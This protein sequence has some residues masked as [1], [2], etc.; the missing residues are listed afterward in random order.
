[1][2]T[3]AHILID[4]SVFPSFPPIDLDINL[5]ESDN[6]KIEKKEHGFSAF[7]SLEWAIPS[8]ICAYFAKSYFDGFLN[9]MGSEHYRKVKSWVFL[10]NKKIK[11][12]TTFQMTST[13]SNKK[14]KESNSP[15]NFFS[16]Y[17]TTPRGIR[18][19]VFMPNCELD[20]D[21]VQAL[22]MLLDNFLKLYTK[23]KSR[24]A[25]KI[26]GLTDK[27]YEELY[28]IFNVEKGNWEFYT[29]DMLVKKSLNKK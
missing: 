18:M 17:L 10:L 12:E 9:E 3:N 4:Q 15:N 2:R 13:K 16:I 14:V 8:V 28:A 24:F 25:Q 1:M 5:L 11:G 26:N 21:D 6:L 29:T 27:V 20:K 7:A 19:K 23:P 22:S